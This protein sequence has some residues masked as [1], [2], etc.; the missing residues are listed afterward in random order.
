MSNADPPDRHQS[1]T[2]STSSPGKPDAITPRAQKATPRVAPA[3]QPSPGANEAEIAKIRRR[4]SWMRLA[5][6]GCVLLVPL[7]C[8][9]PMIVASFFRDNV[10]IVITGV[11]LPLVALGCMIL[12]WRDLRRY[13]RSVALAEQAG[14]MGW[15]FTEKPPP[16]RY[17]RL[18]LLQSFPQA[19]DD[20]GV[21]LLEGEVAGHAAWAIDFTPDS[22]V[23]RGAVGVMASDT[24]TQTVLLLPG[25]ASGLPDFVVAPKGWMDRVGQMFGGRLVELPDYPEFNQQMALR[26]RDAETI[27][28]RLTPEFIALCLKENAVTLEVHDGDLVVLRRKKTLSPTQFV[29]MVEHAD[30]VVEALRSA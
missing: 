3:V 27:A 23:G 15:R 9:G 30:A 29:E 25:A 16:E 21:N 28:S 12:L 17:Y 8:A 14:R 6:W 24:S 13:T 26:G 11:V 10:G 7:G 5:F 20:R 18:K 1:I 19:R 2:D 22:G 4:L